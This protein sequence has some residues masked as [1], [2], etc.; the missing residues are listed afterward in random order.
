MKIVINKSFGD[1]RLSE[2]C[3]KYMAELGSPE[4]TEILN[5]NKIAV[6][7][8]PGFE[9]FGSAKLCGD[10][11]SEEFIRRSKSLFKAIDEL[12]EKCN[13][14]FCKLKIVEV[15]DDLKW[16]IEQEDGCGE[17]IV[18]NSRCFY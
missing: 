9:F 15:P 18:E 10:E 8:H 17:M 12:G 5:S 14:E 11:H 1:F 7:R 4:A 3:V 13:T 16:H 6:E 2:E